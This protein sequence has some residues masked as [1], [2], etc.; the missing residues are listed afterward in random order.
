MDLTLTKR[1]LSTGTCNVFIGACA[2]GC[3]TGAPRAIT[4]ARNVG[5]G[6]AVMYQLGN[7]TNNFAV[8]FHCTWL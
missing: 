4:G 6:E 1:P 7:G 2:A 8:G 3:F 5:L